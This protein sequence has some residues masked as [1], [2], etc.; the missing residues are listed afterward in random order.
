M[1]R[2]H[3]EL[4][5]CAL[6]MKD[7]SLIGCCIL[8]LEVGTRILTQPCTRLQ[9]RLEACIAAK[10]ERRAAAAALSSVEAGIEFHAKA[11][12]FDKLRETAQ[13]SGIATKVVIISIN[14]VPTHLS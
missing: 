11:K 3:L 4:T 14:K 7:E 5:P 6:I 8:G 1:R 12:N 2:W 13:A 9:A 10:A